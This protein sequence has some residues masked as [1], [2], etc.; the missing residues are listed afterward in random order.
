MYIDPL[1]AFGPVGGANI[2]G[3]LNRSD[4]RVAMHATKSPNV[5]Y[6]LGLGNNGYSN[7]KL[8]YAACNLESHAGRG[9]MVQVFQGLLKAAR[10]KSSAANLKRII[11]SSGDIDPVV[12]LHGTEAA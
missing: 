2:P 8:E 6:H 7:Y 4:V 5:H 1:N 11:I 9:S 3:Y 12:E 10:S